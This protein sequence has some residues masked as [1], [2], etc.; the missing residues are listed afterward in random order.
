MITQ[1]SN[2]IPSFLCNR[3]APCCAVGMNNSEPRHD[4]G[5]IKAEA[6]ACP[7]GEK[8]H[9]DPQRERVTSKE[10]ESPFRAGS[11]LKVTKYPGGRKERPNDKAYRE[12]ETRTWHGDS[13]DSGS[14]RSGARPTA[15][16]VP[17]ASQPAPQHPARGTD[18]QDSPLP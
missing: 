18:T 6:R 15:W 17:A 16:H 7:R 4:R 9:R 5:G 2:Y 11:F 12:T 14:L 10:Q 1:V 13:W 8:Q 3:A